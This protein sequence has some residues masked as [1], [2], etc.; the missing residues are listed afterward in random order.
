MRLGID[1][2]EARI[3][4][5][6][7]DAAASLV[8]PLE[9][10]P[11]HPRSRG[12]KRVLR[13]CLEREVIEVVVG[14]PKNMAGN[15]GPAAKKARLFAEEIAKLVSGVRVCLVDE[16]LTTAQAQSKLHEIGIDTRRSRNII[17]QMAAQIILEQALELERSSSLAPGE[18]VGETKWASEGLPG[19]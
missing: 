17:D 5:A 19:G 3:G 2:G 11:A 12:I 10:I 7:S 8:L 1:V 15:E 9:T 4:V 16:R 6:V 18:T 13:I 14:L